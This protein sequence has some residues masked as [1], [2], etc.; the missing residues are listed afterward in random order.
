MEEDVWLIVVDESWRR[1]WLAGA[2]FKISD[3]DVDNIFLTHPDMDEERDAVVLT[4]EDM[5]EIRWLDCEIG[6]EHL[7]GKHRFGC[8]FGCLFKHRS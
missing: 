3:Q 2:R 7:A 4:L 6:L 1:A 5:A 8:P